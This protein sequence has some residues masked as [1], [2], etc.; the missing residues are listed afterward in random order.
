MSAEPEP[1][2]EFPPPPRRNPLL[3]GHQKAE[4]LMRSQ[5]EGGRFHHAWILGGPPG[6]GKATLAYR[7]ARFILAGGNVEGA[8]LFAGEDQAADSGLFIDS[9]TSIFRRIAA[10][11]HP[12]LKTVERGLDPKS[13][14]MRSTITVD[15]VRKVSDFLHKTPGEGGYRVVVVDTLD[16]MNRNAANALLK[17]LEEPPPNTVLLL[18]SHAP[19]RLLPTIRSRCRM[20]R[21]SPLNEPDFAKAVSALDPDLSKTQITD[22]HRISGGSPGEA[23]CLMEEGGIEL[24]G[25]MIDLIETLP[26][27][28]SAALLALADRVSRKEGEAAFRTLTTLLS[29]WLGRLV[30]FGALG[31]GAREDQEARLMARLAGAR[32][33]DQWV[34]VWENLQR[35]FIKTD[36]VYL[37]RRAVVLSAFSTLEKAA[38]PRA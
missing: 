2:E 17:S 30:R 18:A 23:L 36:S 10:S 8:D 14:R 34:E 25:E 32:S 22:L 24:Y 9:E 27:T 31:S 12:D 19:G 20:L 13:G 11:G 4:A 21:L 5:F 26:D 35:L 6:I 37:D 33:L 15:D 3:F 16:E 29:E 28:D 38:R 1:G 7:F